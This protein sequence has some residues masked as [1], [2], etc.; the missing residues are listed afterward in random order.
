MYYINEGKRDILIIPNFNNIKIIQDIRKKYDELFDII[1]PHITLAF[2]FKKD[3]SNDKLK[4]Q[5][6]DIVKNIKP[7]KIKCKGVTLKRDERANT[8]YIFL[9][10]VEG[11]EIINQINQKIYKNI[12]NDIDIRKYNYEPH[13]TL[14]NTNNANEKIEINEEFEAI[15]NSILVEGIGKNEESII[16]FEIYL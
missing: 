3:I 14:G 9:N 5:L 7:F 11:K 10:I 2:P 4:E 8:Y 6:L 1:A 16:E 12:L 15:V 13:I